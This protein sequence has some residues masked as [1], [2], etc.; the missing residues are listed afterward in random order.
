MLR[1]VEKQS[2]ERTG[3][4]LVFTLPDYNACVLCQEGTIT[5]HAIAQKRG[6]HDSRL[7]EIVGFL[8]CSMRCSRLMSGLQGLP[9]GFEAQKDPRILGS[10]PHCLEYWIFTHV[11]TCKSFRSVAALVRPSS[12]DLVLVLL[13]RSEMVLF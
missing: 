6:P 13:Q 8:S 9:T 5:V 4:Q 2:W 7:W 1:H 11:S 3:W 10:K 12:R